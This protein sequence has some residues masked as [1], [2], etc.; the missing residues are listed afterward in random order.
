MKSG[1]CKVIQHSS[2]CPRGAGCTFSRAAHEAPGRLKITETSL[3]LSDVF[4]GWCKRECRERPVVRKTP[5]FLDAQEAVWKGWY[6][7]LMPK[8]V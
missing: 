7:V 4:P 2:P 3:A 5:K 1:K 6:S 8:G